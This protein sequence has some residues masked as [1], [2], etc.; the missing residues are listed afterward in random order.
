MS[1]TLGKLLSLPGTGFLPEIMKWRLWGDLPFQL[2]LPRNLNT[3]CENPSLQEKAVLP[4][5]DQVG[6]PLLS[7]CILSSLYAARDCSKTLEASSSLWRTRLSKGSAY[8]A[9]WVASVLGTPPYPSPSISLISV[10]LPLPFCFLLSSKFKF[11]TPG[12]KSWF[13]SILWSLHSL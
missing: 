11:M 8:C 1:L 10:L 6:F 9:I 12:F 4:Q 7:S 5:C 2:S 13:L 3:I